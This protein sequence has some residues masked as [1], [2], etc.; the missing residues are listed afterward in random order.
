MKTQV[1]CLITFFPNIAPFMRCV[2]KYVHWNQKGHKDITV[3]RTRV[4]CWISKATRTYAHAHAHATEYPQACTHS[5]A[6][7]HRPIC[8]TYCFSRTCLNVTLYTHCPCCYTSAPQSPKDKS[9]A[10][11]R[12]FS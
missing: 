2:E 7:T 4:A 8:N 5:Q 3:W 6:C 1:L 9:T 12:L 10:C 11:F